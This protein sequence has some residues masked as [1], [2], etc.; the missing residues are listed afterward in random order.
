[1]GKATAEL[2]PYSLSLEQLKNWIPAQWE[3]AHNINLADGDVIKLDIF[4]WLIQLTSLI[5]DVSTELG[6]GKGLEQS[7]EAAKDLSQKH[8]KLRSFSKTRF[9]SYDEGVYT[10]F[11]TNY[12]INLKALA[13]HATSSKKYVCDTASSQINKLRSVKF[14]G[15]LC[16]VIDVYTQL[17][18]ISVQKVEKF[19]WEIIN[20]LEE[21]KDHYV[22]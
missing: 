18:K 20:T 8:Y 16:G 21:G 4:V 11:E 22:L 14:A 17:A 6:F 3:P 5:D 2:G 10:N 15:T 9:A 7:F 12:E 1:M 13:V 19:S